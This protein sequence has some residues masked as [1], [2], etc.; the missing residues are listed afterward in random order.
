MNMRM[1]IQRGA[2]ASSSGLHAVLYR[3]KATEAGAAMDTTGARADF[4]SRNEAHGITGFLHREDGAFFQHIEGEAGPVSQLWGALQDDPRHEEVTAL[5]IGP[6]PARRF[7]RWSMGWNEGGQ[8]SLFDWL[9]R[10]GLSLKGRHEA[11]VV[12]AFLEYASGA[13]KVRQGA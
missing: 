2:L 9:A 1:G 11:Q 8:L 5:H 7:A 10:S 4:A 6:L 13:P 12:V 3:S